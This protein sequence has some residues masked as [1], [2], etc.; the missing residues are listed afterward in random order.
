MGEEDAISS[1]NSPLFFKPW[2]IIHVPGPLLGAQELYS[3]TRDS[4]IK[5]HKLGGMGTEIDVLTVLEPR[6]A[7]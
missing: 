3:Y 4:T 1:K 5:A 7:Q 6:S 2:K